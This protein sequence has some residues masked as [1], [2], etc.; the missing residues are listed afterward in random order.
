M[1]H[2]IHITPSGL[3]YT[4]KENQTLLDCALENKIVLP[5]ACKH[6]ACGV[7]KTK[8]ISGEILYKEAPP[9]WALSEEAKNQGYILTCLAQPQ[10]DIQLECAEAVEAI[11]PPVHNFRARV[12]KMELLAPCVMRVFLQ[13]PAQLDFQFLPGQYIQFLAEDGRPRAFS[14]AGVEEGILELHIRKTSQTGFTHFVFSALKEKDVLNAMGPKGTFFIR[15]ETTPLIFFSGGTGFAPIKAI[16]TAWA[17]LNAKPPVYLYWGARKK[18]DFYLK[19]WVEDFAKAQSLF[20]FI[21]VLSEETWQGR[22]GLV[23]EALLNDFKQNPQLQ[24]ASVYACGTPAMV[25]SAKESLLNAGLPL[26][27]FFSDAF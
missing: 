4:A 3:N 5:H 12:K 14:I 11:L 1:S 22:T 9:A 25:L 6:G 13:L 7:C 27:R 23:G 20:H 8:K 19:N 2:S 18:E 15:D 16:L 24:S 17:K 26:N 21:P 10:S